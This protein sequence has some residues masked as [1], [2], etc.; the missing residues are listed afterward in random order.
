MFERGSYYLGNVGPMPIYVHPSALLLVFLSF[1]WAQ[2]NIS[3]GVCILIALVVGITLHELGHGLAAL[4]QGARGVT[5]TLWAM[6][7]VCQSQRDSIGRPWREVIILAAGP[8]VSFLLAWSALLIGDVLAMTVPG[9]LVDNA[10]RWPADMILEHWGR[11]QNSTM[12]AMVLLYMFWV[13]MVLGIFNCLPIFPLDGGQILY[14]S[15]RGF[16]VRDATAK[17][18]TLVAAY[19]VGVGL[20]VYSSY[21]N[22]GIPRPWTVIMVIGLLMFSTQ[23]LR[24][25]P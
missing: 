12:L 11:L 9:S 10:D 7:G 22:G 5:V 23:A 13:N 8:A 4:V 14:N 3:I 21:Q 25:R 16:G 2:W 1:Y 15:Q 24:N 20:L 18:V 19:V 6:G 17:Q